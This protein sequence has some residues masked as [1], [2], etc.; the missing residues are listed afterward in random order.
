MG[1]DGKTLQD[2]VSGFEP[3]TDVERQLNED[4]EL[5]DGMSWGE[6]RPG[7]PEGAIAA[8]VSDLLEKVDESGATGPKRR[9]LRFLVI[10]H[11]AFKKRQEELPRE[12]DNHHARLARDFAA[13]YTDDENLLASLELHDRPF[14]LWK[15]RR[16]Q[17]RLDEAEFKKLVKE[18]P[19]PEFFMQFCELDASTAGKDPEPLR[20]LRR[21][22][23][24]RGALQKGAQSAFARAMWT[25]G[26]G[27]TGTLPRRRVMS[28]GAGSGA[29]GGMPAGGGVMFVDKVAVVG[30]G[31]MG[32][33]IAQVCA[34]AGLPTLLKDV[35]QDKLDKG[36]EQ[37][38][39]I[40]SREFEGQVEK[41]RLSEEEAGR[42][43]DEVV[44]LITPQLDYDGFSEVDLVIEA[45]PEDIEIKREVFGE[46]DEAAPGHAMLASNTSSLAIT[47]MGAATSRPD[48][49]LGLHFFHPASRMRLVEV[50]SGGTTSPKT[51]RAAMRFAQQVRK[52]PIRCAD[53]PGFVVYRVLMAA[54][55]EIWR[56][57]HEHDSD[58]Q[59][60]DDAVTGE[61]LAPMGPFALTDEIGLDKVLKVVEHLNENMGERFFVSPEMKELVEEGNL[62]RKTGKGFHEYSS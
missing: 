1:E 19:D 51:V 49:V 28:P 33:E 40:T 42:R 32:G 8:H 7:H 3:E 14:Q 50:V 11:D 62:G 10:V 45:V 12:P 22:L 24:E 59:E 30:A 5:L 17:G 57:H 20:W 23:T 58:V 38:R 4:D 61:G 44:D 31:T 46:L 56:E 15:D 53:E 29:P 18:L 6:P 48:K 21:E 41:G 9:D 36:Y 35:D 25:H 52:Q 13:R 26:G 55:D 34:A 47:E 2:V 16:R 60:I 54:L 27:W 43:A 39:K 37:A